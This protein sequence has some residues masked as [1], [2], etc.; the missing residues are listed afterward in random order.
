MYAHQILSPGQKCS[1]SGRNIFQATLALKDRIAE[2]NRRGLRGKLVSFDLDHAF[3]RVDHAFLFRIMR[4]LG[5][6]PALVNLLSRIAESSRSRLMINGHLSPDFSIRRSVRQGDPLSMHLF[7]LYLHPL[8]TRLERVAGSDLVV[9]YAD[10]IS[11]VTTSIHK[12]NRMRALFSVFERASGAKLNL[13]K[14]TSIDV[15]LVGDN[16]IRTSWLQTVDTIN[17]LGI[18]YA[19]SLRVMIRLN[20]DEV[21]VKFARLVWLH[22]TRSLTLLQKVVLLNTFISAKMWYL[23]SILPPYQEHTSKITQTM[24]SFLWRGLPARVPMQQLARDREQG[25]LKLQLPALKCKALLINRHLREIESI[26]FYK[27]FLVQPNPNLVNL[28]TQFPCLKYICE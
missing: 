12:L 18:T 17:I 22:A 3:D 20:W 8:V 14:T 11:V 26:P 2:L 27:S 21:V 28:P 13:R 16:G 5:F 15:G 19:N 4:S 6:H 1:N 10:D 24:G 7:V 23:S 9:A 25:G